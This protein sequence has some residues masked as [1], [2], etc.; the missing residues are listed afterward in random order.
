MISSSKIHLPVNYKFFLCFWL[1]SI[2]F[3]SRKNVEINDKSYWNHSIWLAKGSISQRV[4]INHTID[5]NCSLKPQDSVGDFDNK[6]FLIFRKCMKSSENTIRPSCNCF[7]IHIVM[8]Y[9]P[10]QIIIMYITYGKVFG[11]TPNILMFWIFP[12]NRSISERTVNRA[13]IV[14]T[15]L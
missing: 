12:E 9:C 6:K 14:H 3:V 1:S 10:R 5:V 2:K 15:T 7:E 11:G 13:L 8:Q 4:A